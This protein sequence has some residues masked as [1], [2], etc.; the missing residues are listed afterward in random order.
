MEE[1]WAAHG[2]LYKRVYNHDWN[3]ADDHYIKEDAEDQV[4]AFMD[5]Q[6]ACLKEIKIVADYEAWSTPHPPT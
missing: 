5:G 1:V 4:D 6:L 2:A 3:K